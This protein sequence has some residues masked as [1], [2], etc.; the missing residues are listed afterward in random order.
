MLK[1]MEIAF[2]ELLHH[3]E[4]CLAKI[5]EI[6]TNYAI[7]HPDEL[8]QICK[9]KY[10]ISQM[11]TGGDWPG[12]MFLFVSAHAL[13]STIIVFGFHSQP[14]EYNPAHEHI[15]HSKSM[16]LF[17]SHNHYSPM[18]PDN[19]GQMWDSLMAS[20]CHKHYLPRQSKQLASL[21]NRF[22]FFVIQVTLW[23]MHLICCSFSNSHPVSSDT[24]SHNSS[25]V[26]KKG[27]LLNDLYKR[28][29]LLLLNQGCCCKERIHQ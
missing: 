1:G 8:E 19:K 26:A 7:Q 24:E 9:H 21:Q 5:K 3:D 27:I 2:Q 18:I 25:P 4:A 6:V 23:C 11:V 15:S 22:V 16:K 29:R 10:E 28:Q 17:F 20:H 13:K 12:D 14:L